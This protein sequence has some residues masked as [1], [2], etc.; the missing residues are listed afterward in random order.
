[1]NKRVVLIFDAAQRSALASTRALGKRSD[2]VVYTC[3]S[4]PMA[5]AG[6]SAYSHA[7]LKCPDPTE[8]AAAFVS[9]VSDLSL[10]HL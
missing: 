7:Y 8:D 6:R 9:W 2:I 10:I 4:L 5:L 3:D 1:M